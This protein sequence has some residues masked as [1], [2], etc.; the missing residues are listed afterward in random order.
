ML[1]I[2]KFPDEVQKLQFDLPSAYFK[3]FELSLTNLTPWHFLDDDGFIGV[4]DVLKELYN[5]YK[6]IPFARR[7]DNDD[8]ACVVV[9]SNQ[10]PANYVVVIHMFASSGDE[11]DA[12]YETFWEWFRVAIDEMIEAITL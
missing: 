5:N 7:I 8:V 2:N 4:Y 12:V 10:Y 6:V 1:N 3:V 11:I 9:Q